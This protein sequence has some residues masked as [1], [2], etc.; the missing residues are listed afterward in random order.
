MRKKLNHVKKVYEWLQTKTKTP[1]PTDYNP[2]LIVKEEMDLSESDVDDFLHLKFEDIKAQVH[3]IKHIGERAATVFQLK[4][5]VRSSELG[6]IRFKDIHIANAEV[7]NHYSDL[8]M[9]EHPQ[10]E[11]RPNAVYIPM[12]RAENKRERPTVIPLDDETRRVLI[13]WL[14]IRPDNGDPHVFLTQ[15][16][17]P[18]DRNSLRHVWTKHWHPEYKFEDGE[19]VRSISPHFAR[20]WFTTWW[21]TK[22]HV[23]LEYDLYL[24]GDK[25]RDL[26]STSRAAIHHYIHTYYE[27][28][29][30]TYREKVFKLGI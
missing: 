4:T 2:Y 8:D 15:K 27:D 14:L 5:G 18:M 9:G 25:Q 22:M 29:E 3:N 20:H 23:P 17:K 11:D 6:N 19:E 28:V 24:R 10:L 26:E 21:H 1:I 30:D 7:L 13:D 16:G 12:D